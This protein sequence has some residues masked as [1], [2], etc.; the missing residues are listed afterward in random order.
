MR[1]HLTGILIMVLAFIIAI[2]SVSFVYAENTTAAHQ[3]GHRARNAA[4]IKVLASFSGNS[5]EEI[6]QTA[7]ELRSVGKLINAVILK[8]AA[9]ITLDEA[10]NIIKQEQLREY[11]QENQLQAKF[12]AT[13]KKLAHYMRAAYQ[14]YKEH[15]PI[16]NK[17]QMRNRIFNQFINKLS[18]WSG[19]SKEEI[20]QYAS[21][22]KPVRILNMVVLAKAANISIEKAHQIII[23]GNLR[24][25]LSEHDLT[26][27]FIQ[28]R[29]DAIKMLRKH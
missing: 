25:Y 13:K 15:K 2:S 8:K 18:S 6:I 4:I 29:Q 19:H 23:D 24:Q 17:S 9:D 5:E 10:A 1:K 16:R 21:D 3:N 28:L 14:R 7:K 22:M 12:I 20:M 26:R 27:Q 11:L